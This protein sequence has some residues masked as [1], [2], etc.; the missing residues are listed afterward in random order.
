MKKVFLIIIT[1]FIPVLS[2][3]QMVVSA[4]L[5][6]A[7]GIANMIQLI[8]Q[9]QNSI[10]SIQNQIAQIEQMKQQIEAQVE[11]MKQLESPDS[12]RDLISQVNANMTF[13]RNMEN[14]IKS[15]TV[16]I[17]NTQIPLT[18][19]Y[20]VD[21]VIDV[22]MDDTRKVIE[23]DY[24]ESERA[25]IYSTIGLDAS[26]F[27]WLKEKQRKV[28]ELGATASTLYERNKEQFETD[29]EALQDLEEQVRNAPSAQAV[30]QADF[31]ASKIVASQNAEMTILMG[32]I[33]D[34]LAMMN[35]EI[36][37]QPSS[38]K[39]IVGASDDFIMD[40]IIGDN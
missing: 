19:M 27:K 9:V 11:M 32:V 26:N 25:Y 40:I 20:K 13:I 37:T 39:L 2:H 5:L 36:H 12:V 33:A 1:L 17:G 31:Y 10:S 24:T 14:Q 29:Q 35:T 34:S 8:T 16:T 21:Q 23:A 6:E 7:Q 15:A 3:S 4:P 30:A 38:N 18:E 28:A 22:F